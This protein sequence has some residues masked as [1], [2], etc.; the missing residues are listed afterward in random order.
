MLKQIKTFSLYGIK[1]YIVTAEI[2]IGRGLPSCSIV[3]LPDTSVREARD[4]L[5]SALANSGFKMPSSRILINLSPANV[6]KEGTQLDLAMAVGIL[7]AGGFVK[8]VDCPDAL[9]IGELSLSGKVKTCGGI[10]PAML[11]ASEKK[12]N[13]V[14]IPSANC[15]EAASVK[16][17]EI[18]GVKSVRELAD[19]LNGVAEIS[20]YGG[21]PFRSPQ[22]AYPDFS[23]VEGQH[24]VKR[25]L[26]VAAAGAHNVLMIGPPGSGKTMLAMRMPGILPP[27][28]D[29]EAMDVSCIYSAC[30]MLKEGEGLMA[31][32]PFRSPHHTISD[33][34]LVGGG[35]SARPGEI[36]LAHRGILFLDEF[37]EFSRRAV[38]A[39]RAPMEDGHITVS[40][41]RGTSTFPASFMLVAAMNPCPCGYHGHPTKECACTPYRIKKYRSR[42]SGPIMDRIDIQVELLPETSENIYSG[43]AAE[44]S[45]AVR[46]RVTAARFKSLAR[47]KG[48]KGVYANARL[49]SDDLKTFCTISPDA[50]KLLRRALAQFSISRRGADKILKVSRTIA[51][52]AGCEKIS[53]EHI[54]EA[55]QYRMDEET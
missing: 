44:S 46:Q 2:D 43:E 30:N 3:G 7:C 42:I 17:I 20:P 53:D 34:A 16:G 49:D 54:A 32:R 13:K 5:H 41:V 4:R 9:F 47:L 8:S 26:E 37:P 21:D 25:A 22:R 48:K 40:R 27:M 50:A 14:Y 15:A 6:K 12:I 31:N 10:I 28:T 33:V 38:E 11:A 35:S 18:I 39:M 36:S 1:A 52:L 45:V 19:H 23:D 24:F 29:G 55:L 51:D